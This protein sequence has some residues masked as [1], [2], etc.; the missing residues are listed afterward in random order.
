MLVAGFILALQ[1]LLVGKGLL[2]E[3]EDV[4]CSFLFLVLSIACFLLG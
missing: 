4:F 2:D 3:Q 1:I